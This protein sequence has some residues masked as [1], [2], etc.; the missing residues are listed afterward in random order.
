MVCEAAEE[1]ITL[2]S[3]EEALWVLDVIE[4]LHDKSLL[5]TWH[6]PEF[7]DDIRRYV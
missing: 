5:H 4:S 2:D 1:L 6:V 3:F 7:P